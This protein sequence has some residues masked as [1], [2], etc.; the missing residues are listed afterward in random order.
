VIAGCLLAPR[1][2][3]AAPPA[4]KAGETQKTYTA[5]LTALK[6]VVVPG[7]SG[8]AVAV[9]KGQLIK[10]TDV[11]GQQVGD[12]FAILRADPEMY[13]CTFRSRTTNRKL[14]P[15]VGEQFVTLE[16]Q[17]VLK[18]LSDHSPG[19]HDMLYATCDRNTYKLRGAGDDHPNCND[20]F[21]NAVREI[22]LTHFKWAPGPVNIFQNTPV[23]PDGT[24]SS[25]K[26]LTEAGDFLEF[27]AELDIYLV[28]TACSYDLPGSQI[29]GGKSS[30]LLIEV[31]E[32]VD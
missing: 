32:A 13:L 14:F 6:T 17:P 16:R 25:G 1:T 26:G 31:F 9:D 8:K 24:L 11:K 23:N 10:I 30:P 20:N 5:G 28:L 15:A 27:R 21:L 29:N 19:V 4:T 12:L 22:G 3:A 7:Y 18:F 2:T